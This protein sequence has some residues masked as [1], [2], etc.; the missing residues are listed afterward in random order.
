MSTLQSLCHK[1]SNDTLFN[2]KDTRL[3]SLDKYVTLKERF[4]I[5]WL[6]FERYSQ[7]QN[8]F[9][10]LNNVI[11]IS[12]LQQTHI[13]KDLKN[14]FVS[15]CKIIEELSHNIDINLEIYRGYKDISNMNKLILDF[16]AF[17]YKYKIGNKKYYNAYL[18]KQYIQKNS[19]LIIFIAERNI[20]YN[21]LNACAREYR[22]QI[23][24]EEMLPEECDIF[25]LVE[26]YYY[27]YKSLIEIKELLHYKSK[28]NSHNSNEV[29]ILNQE[30]LRKQSVCRY[31]AY[32]IQS[33][34]INDK[35]LDFWQFKNSLLVEQLRTKLQ[36]ERNK[37]SPISTIIEQI[38]ESINYLLSQD[39]QISIHAREH[40][41]LLTFNKYVNSPS[42][43]LASKIIQFL[44]DDF[45]QIYEAIRD[46]E[47]NWEGI[48]I[49][50]QR[51][52]KK[53]MCEDLN[54]QE[55]IKF[56]VV[57]KYLTLDNEI[58]NIQNNS[59]MD[60]SNI[61]EKTFLENEILANIGEYKKALD[62]YNFSQEQIT[63]FKRLGVSI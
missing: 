43:A 6:R 51:F 54:N 19:F 40:D 22:K 62:F 10:Y 25:S 58:Q 34:P 13:Y 44:K 27:N 21:I 37:T 11:K 8:K 28:Y 30:V 16:R 57:E 17:I 42:G 14:K 56:D 20:S 63:N 35:I 26:D 9:D 32:K 49:H 53:K 3:I 29:Q 2:A 59:Y 31:I 46:K 4:D 36:L 50:A 45:D 24:M 18:I 15:I 41:F 47:V 12:E 48:L 39:K 5:A 60:D 7:E 52:E 23:K 38:E 55:K 33:S 61:K 1:L